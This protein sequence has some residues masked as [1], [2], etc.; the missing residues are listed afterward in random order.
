MKKVLYMLVT[1]DEY[2]LPLV[3]VDTAKEL[4]DICGVKVDSVY[5][6]I[7]K[8]KGNYRKVVIDDK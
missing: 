6:L 1:K 5:T 4:A 8:H 3:V 2:E 7:S